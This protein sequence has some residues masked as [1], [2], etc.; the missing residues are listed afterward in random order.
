MN[1]DR[2][3]PW[4]WFPGKVPENV[5]VDSDAYV[6]T[7]FSFQLFRSEVP[8]A[9]RVGK[10]AS[11]YLGVMFDLG[12]NARVTIGDFALIHGARI[13]CDSEI[14]IGEY[15]MIS[16]NVV[17]MDNYR[18]PADVAAR[19]RELERVAA[20]TPRYAAHAGSARP[21]KIGRNVWIGFESCILPGITIGDGAVVG[22]RSVVTDAVPPYTVVAGNPARVVRELP[23]EEGSTY[24]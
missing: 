13:I 5:A 11:L 9:V 17:L 3:L 12:S 18:V 15:S 19:R 16:W 10:G 2:T 4:D 7:T 20:R 24:A 23:R 22:A 21:I 1:D 6:E 14:A 8:D